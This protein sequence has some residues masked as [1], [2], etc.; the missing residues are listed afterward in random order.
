MNKTN[1]SD[2]ELKQLKEITNHRVRF[3]G[4]EFIWEHNIDNNWNRH[5]V[6]NFIDYKKPM[7]WIHHNI[8]IWK[9]EYNFRKSKY[10]KNMERDLDIQIKITEISREASKRTKIKIQEIL[11]IKPN[12]TNKDIA[13]VLG[14]TKRTVE[15]YRKYNK[16]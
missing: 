6:S 11:N 12:I 4:Y 14:V 13:D 16:K 9:K 2:N 3:D 5:Y 7:S 10:L 8:H 1:W 15:R